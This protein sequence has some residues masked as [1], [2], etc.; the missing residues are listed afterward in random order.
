M[1]HIYL[2]T[3]L[4]KNWNFIPH[5]IEH[6]VFWK[7]SE[8]NFF[9]YKSIDAWC[10][11]YHSYFIL[12]T[13]EKKELN[14]FIKQILS[15]ISKETIKYEHKVIKEESKNKNYSQ[16]LI[17]KIGK[18]LYW[19]TFKYSNSDKIIYSKIQK[20]HEKYYVKNNI[21]ILENNTKFYEKK[22]NSNLD[23]YKKIEIKI[24][25]DKDTVYIFKHWIVELYIISLLSDLIDNYIN[26]WLRYQEYKYNTSSYETIYWDFEDYI[27]LAITPK[28]INN[29]KK[30]NSNFIKNYIN[31]SL[32]KKTYIEDKDFDGSCMV[33]YWYTLSNKQ[34]K[35]I[36]NNLNK[37]YTKLILLL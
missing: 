18:I 3:P 23:L 8:N 11:I 9:K 13:N 30:I 24:W 26:F 31:Y 4:Y 10:Y 35:E 6:S 36:L 2:Y 12:N 15:T 19:N 20:Y 28:M 33:K 37:Y 32:S 16:K 27:Y 1:Y 29:V 25:M 21:I 5:I 14:D 34:K 17:W 22:L 7:V